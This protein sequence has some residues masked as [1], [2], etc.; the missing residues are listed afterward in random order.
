MLGSN[1]TY[2]TITGNLPTRA[3][4]SPLSRC[5]HIPTAPGVPRLSLQALDYADS[6][7]AASTPCL[8]LQPN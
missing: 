7:V 1:S 3:I 4:V 2:K 8:Q 6:L 5:T